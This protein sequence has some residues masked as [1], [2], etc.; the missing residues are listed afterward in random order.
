M[1]R[2]DQVLRFLSA[3]FRSVLARGLPDGPGRSSQLVFPLLSFV[4]DAL[5]GGSEVPD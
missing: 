2:F 1:R 4:V 3:N 5:R